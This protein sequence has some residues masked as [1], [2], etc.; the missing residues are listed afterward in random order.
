METGKKE[1]G[2]RQGLEDV[3]NDSADPQSSELFWFNISS[4]GLAILDTS[5]TIIAINDALIAISGFSREEIVNRSA[6]I[7]AKKTLSL[8]DI[9]RSLG[10]LKKILAGETIPAYQG[11][12]N[13]KKIEVCAS[14]HVLDGKKVIVTRINDITDRAIAG[15]TARE[16][17]KVSEDFVRF[18]P[19]GVFLF[20]SHITEG[21][22]TLSGGNLEAE[23][24]TGLRVEE[25]LGK[26]FADM[27]P[28]AR[29][30]GLDK[31]TWEVIKS[32][33]PFRA[34]EF[35]YSDV[36]MSG[37]FRINVF[38]LPQGRVALCFEN[39]TELKR[40]EASMRARDAKLSS[41]FRAAPTGIGLV[42]DQVLLEVNDQICAMTGYQ[43]RELVGQSARILYL[44]DEDFEFVGKEKY[45]QIQQSGI[46][47]VET[48]WKRKDG[49]IIDVLLNSTPVIQ[50]DLSQGITFTALDMSEQKKNQLAFQESERKLEA[51]LVKSQKLESIGVLA[52][53]IA[54]DYN[55]LLCGL[56]GYMDMAREAAVNDARVVTYLSKALE[57]FNRA[58]DLTRQLLTFSK[59]GQ[60]LKKT[61]D[62]APLIMSNVHFVLSGSNVVPLF[63]VAPDLWMCE[64]DENQFG[65]VID[66]IVIN[67]RQAMADGG[68]IIVEAENLPGDVALPTALKQGK[69][70]RISI[71]DHG[72][73]IA[74]ENLPKV[75]DP[76][77]TT[78]QQ[79][80]GL[81][82]ATAYSIISKHAGHIEIESIE[83]QGATVRIY[84]PASNNSMTDSVEHRAPDFV[85]H[86]RV[87]V[88]DDEEFMRALI[89]EML[90]SMG[91]NVICV[92]DG[93][94]A[95]AAFDVSRSENMSFILAILDL[96]IP[97]GM[98][99]RETIQKLRD[100]DPAIRVIA[101][102][103]YSTDPVMVNPREF[104]FSSKLEKPFRRDDMTKV[105]TEVL[106]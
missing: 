65:Q 66:N 54:H 97:G 106:G 33:E 78:K 63:A 92:A 89:K 21:T 55:N 46:A 23:H 24:A 16:S 101:S 10:F 36:R 57:V 5:G 14:T 32:G 91:F 4:E 100:I 31:K 29:E 85:G 64:L 75:F 87:L 60:P 51:E 37:I 49:T 48:H 104:G 77:F 25:W 41:I 58:Q 83:G 11:R 15:E 42:N 50:N 3:I 74:P 80:S 86:G 28:G 70:I 6:I 20:R 82:L 2:T 40:V 71:I 96:T 22:L 53:G 84:M 13:G 43:A 44:S 69:Y 102:S 45:R 52:G 7:V 99:G 27:F 95:V 1:H 8:R 76:F 105:L 98:G 17:L 88:L 26:D 47:T 94:N 68:T 81:G 35:A 56:F 30:T 72:T 93:D 79:G 34:E 18:I 61:I 103:G 59:G 9:P 19:S 67:S 39:I 12:L 62:I 90:E 38:S 73:G